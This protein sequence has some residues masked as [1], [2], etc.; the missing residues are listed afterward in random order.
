MCQAQGNNIDNETRR[1]AI[2]RSSSKLQK[3]FLH[4]LNL[5]VFKDLGTLNSVYIDL[6]SP[7]SRNIF[8]PIRKL[9][10]PRLSVKLSFIYRKS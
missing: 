7:H 10:E 9:I 6:V 3:H 2:G 4:I 1:R 5:I 8:V